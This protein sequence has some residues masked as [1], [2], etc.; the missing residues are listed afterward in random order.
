LH[1]CPRIAFLN[2]ER[3]GA[4]ARIGAN[5]RLQIGRIMAKTEEEEVAQVLMD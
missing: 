5:T 2:D 3:S 1:F 4:L